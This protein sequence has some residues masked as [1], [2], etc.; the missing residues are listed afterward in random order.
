MYCCSIFFL[1]QTASGKEEVFQL[2]ACIHEANMIER[3]TADRPI[4]FEMSIGKNCRKFFLFLLFSVL[5]TN[6]R[7]QQKA[8]Q[9]MRGKI[10]TETFMIIDV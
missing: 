3:K 2:F 8:E 5:F 1:Q 7:F 9:Y 6:H 4:Q 10:E